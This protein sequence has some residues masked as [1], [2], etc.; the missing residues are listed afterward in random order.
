VSQLHTKAIIRL[1]AKVAKFLNL[2]QNLDKE[3]EKK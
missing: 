2:S 1:R 3:F